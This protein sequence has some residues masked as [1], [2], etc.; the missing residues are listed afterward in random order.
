MTE[1]MTAEEFQQRMADGGWS[2]RILAES[3]RPK[4]SLGAI[5]RWRSGDRRCPP[6]LGKAMDSVEK[7]V[8]RERRRKRQP[9]APKE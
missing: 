9:V 4:V 8:P 2:Y 6:W 5:T 7:R 1:R 3:L